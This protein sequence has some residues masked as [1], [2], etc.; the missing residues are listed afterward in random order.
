MQIKWR[1]LFYL[2]IQ[3]IQNEG[4]K[5]KDEL[6]TYYLLMFLVK[7]NFNHEKMSCL[8]FEISFVEM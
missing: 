5:E 1:I 4:K 8:E 6:V 3:I 7:N 2:K